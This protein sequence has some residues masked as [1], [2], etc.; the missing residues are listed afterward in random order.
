MDEAK[1]VGAD[2]LVATDD[3]SAIAIFP[4]SMR[5]RIL[6]AE[7]PPRSWSPR[8]SREGCL[9]WFSGTTECGEVP[10]LKGRTG[11]RDT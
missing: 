10:N 11:V 5:W 7:E 3:D 6:S 8:S 2:Q 1:T 9:L 4:R